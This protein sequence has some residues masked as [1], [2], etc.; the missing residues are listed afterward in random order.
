[1]GVISGTGVNRCP[2]CD[3]TDQNSPETRG[4]G[5]IMYHCFG[6][7]G[8]F[9]ETELSVD[10]RQEF[11]TGERCLKKLSDPEKELREAE[12]FYHYNQALE[13]LKRFYS[14]KRLLDV[15]CCGTGAF[16]KLVE[17]LGFEVSLTPREAA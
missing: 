17:K 7:G 11:E 12:A 14:S 3:G 5:Y 9:A 6:C 8:D 15:A 13:F 10:Y 2:I 16:P 1:M 4:E